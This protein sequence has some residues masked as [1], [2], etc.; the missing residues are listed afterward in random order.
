MQ[1]LIHQQMNIISGAVIFLFGIYAL[2]VLDK[3]MLINK[4]YI[5]SL[6]LNLLLI[7]LEMM[8]N[9]LLEAGIALL[10]IR[11]I[12]FVLYSLSPLLSYLFLKFICSYFLSTYKIKKPVSTFFNLLLIF[13]TIASFIASRIGK[14]EAGSFSR[15]IIALV[16]SFVFLLYSLYVI[17]INKKMLL[18]FEFA[19]IMAISTVTNIMV[20]IQMSLSQVRFIWCSSTFTI[21]MMFIVIQQRELYRD[22]LTGA[23]NRAV[24][25]KCLDAY[26]RKNEGTLSAIMIDLDYFKDINDSYGHME[27]DYALKT[28]AKLLQKVYS[29]NGI[30]IRLGGDEFII[31]IYGLSVSKIN[32]LIAKM[33]KMVDKYNTRCGKPYLLRYSC[34]CDTYKNDMS[35]EQFIHEIDLKMYD[36]KNRRKRKLWSAENE[37]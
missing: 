18:K 3:K 37:Y 29:D 17:V 32:D 31:L 21:I 23:R 6:F 12:N 10:W 13:N 34:A 9:I 1:F 15:N 16:I 22:S 7:N 14:I 8:Q 33:S 25:K 11:V 27:G 19:Y 4:I 36:H 30:V 28:F 2:S 26:S 24:L 35:L 5:A 20:I